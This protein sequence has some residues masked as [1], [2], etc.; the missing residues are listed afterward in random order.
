M[1][2]V[3]IKPLLTGSRQS[4]RIPNSDIR[5]RELCDDFERLL[6]VY[7]EICNETVEQIEVAC[8]GLKRG[9]AAGLYC[10]LSNA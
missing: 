2:V 3:M 1:V 8:K 5:H 7:D 6:R 10:L 9:K 4:V